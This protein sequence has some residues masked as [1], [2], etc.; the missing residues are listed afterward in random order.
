MTI[1][2]VSNVQAPLHKPGKAS[3]WERGERIPQVDNPQPTRGVHACWPLPHLRVA[4]M[5]PGAVSQ[6]LVDG[7]IHT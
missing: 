7:G 5:A 6:V 4:S 2:L 1:T 3:C